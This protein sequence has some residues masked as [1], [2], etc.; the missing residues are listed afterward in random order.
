[1]AGKINVFIRIA[2]YIIIFGGLL[3]IKSKFQKQ[4]YDV[5]LDELSGI[6]KQTE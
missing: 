3:I 2:W 4:N 6:L 5:Y 1:M